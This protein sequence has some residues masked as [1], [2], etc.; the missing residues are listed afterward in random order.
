MRLR[1]LG[2][3]RLL[4]QISAKLPRS[5]RGVV[6]GIGDDCAVVETNGR[7]PWLLLKTDA[8]VENVHF[9]SGTPAAAIGWKAMM[10]PLSDFAAMSGV[11]RWAMI[12]LAVPRQ[13]ALVW[14]RQLYAGIRNAAG[15]FDVA[16]VGGETTATRRTAVIAVSLAGQV[17]RARCVFRNGGKPDDDLFVTGSLGG[18]IRKKHLAFEARIEEARWLTENFS[19]HAMIDLSDGLGADLPRLARA[20]NLQFELDESA[21]PLSRGCTPQE[22]IG[23][24]EDY[25]LLFALSANDSAS[26][27][28]RWR[29]QFRTLRL[30]RIGRLVRKQ[31]RAMLKLPPGYDHFR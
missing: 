25:E 12:T 20:S 31:R 14:V 13:T 15:R 18:A 27:Q 30:T 2:E 1:G 28:Q 9:E 24:G 29:K 5:A 21:L 22:A 10:R 17:E 23:G 19:I 8:V 3:D 26:L 11:P 4:A 6:R 7:A 16:I